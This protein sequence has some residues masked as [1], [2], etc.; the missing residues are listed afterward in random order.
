[1]TVNIRD[2]QSLSSVMTDA[3][4]QAGYTSRCHSP[5]GRTMDRLQFRVR[6]ARAATKMTQEAF[7]LRLGVSRSAVANWETGVGVPDM[8][9]LSRICVASG[10]AFEY[11]ATGRGER[12]AD[13]SAVTDDAGGYM[14]PDESKAQDS[15]ELKLLKRYRACSAEKRR[16]ILS[17]LR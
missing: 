5:V 6:E 13:G 10:M 14:T 15:D 8:Q 7:A 11:L 9:N 2:K 1:M 17:L 12:F 4:C 3:E 16:A